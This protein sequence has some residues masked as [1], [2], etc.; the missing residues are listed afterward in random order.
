MIEANKGKKLPAEK[1]KPG[2]AENEP[3]VISETN[4]G[5]PV[6]GTPVVANGVVYVQSN[7][8]L[9]AFYNAAARGGPT[10]LP[11]RIDVNPKK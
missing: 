7:T 9:F 11:P 2:G 3:N 1:I 5:S 4:L 8:H 10:D 6:Y